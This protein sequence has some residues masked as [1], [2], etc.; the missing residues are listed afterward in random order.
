MPGRLQV[1]SGGVIYADD[2][3]HLAAPYV[4]LGQA[5]QPPVL[6]GQEPFIFTQTD[7]TGVTTALALAPTLRS[8]QPDCPGPPHRHRQSLAAGHRQRQLPRV[9]W[10]HPREWHVE[11]GR[12]PP[13]RSRADLSD[14]ARQ[15]QRSSST[16]TTPARD[17]RRLDHHPG[18]RSAALPLSGGGTLSLYAS[19]IHQGGTLRAPIGVINLGWNGSGTAPVDPIAGATRPSPVTSIDPGGRQ[20]SPLFPR[21]I[22]AR[23]EASSFPMESVSTA[24]R[25]SILP[26]M[27]SRWEACPPRRS[28]FRSEPDHRAGLMIDIAGGGDLFA[29]RWI[30]GTGGS[31][32]ILA[33]TTAFAVIPGFDFNYAPFAP[34]NPNSSATNLGGQPGYVNGSLRVGDQV[35]LGGGSGTARRHLHAIPRPLRVAAGSFSRHTTE[36]HPGRLGRIAG[37][38][39]PRFRLSGQLP[40][41]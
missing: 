30:A 23:A 13:A 25:G 8:R 39:E 15:V 26:G 6:A 18:R 35:T 9:A 32:D 4:A 33:S 38:C 31:Q 16:T 27:T 20:S 1:A 14:H 10:R 19:T 28:T 12:R 29:Y 24:S 2:A 11:H 34:F 3:V 22:R 7:A 17:G 5:F 37:W 41:W 40:R 36:W 21:L